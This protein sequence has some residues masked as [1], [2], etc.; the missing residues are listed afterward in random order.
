MQLQD[1]SIAETI[2]LDIWYSFR[3]RG[4]GIVDGLL[5]LASISLNMLS[6]LEIHDIIPLFL[7]VRSDRLNA[8]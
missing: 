4:R 6:F 7:T 5:E 2:I 1:P 3:M 8:E